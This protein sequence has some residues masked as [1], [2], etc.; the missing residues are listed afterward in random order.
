MVWHWNMA[1]RMSGCSEGFDVTKS[2]PDS[3]VTSGLAI[4]SCTWIMCNGRDIKAC[5]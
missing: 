1:W 4:T 5:A 2:W 3:H